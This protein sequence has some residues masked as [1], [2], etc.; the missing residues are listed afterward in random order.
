MRFEDVRT[1]IGPSQGHNLALTGLFVPSSL[2][3]GT[4][5]ADRNLCFP[6]QVDTGLPGKENSRPVH[7]IISL[8]KRIRTSRL[9]I[10]NSLSLDRNRRGGVPGESGVGECGTLASN[11]FNAGWCVGGWGTLALQKLHNALEASERTAHAKGLAVLK[12]ENA[13]QPPVR[14]YSRTKSWARWWSWGEGGGSD[15]RGAPLHITLRF[16]VGV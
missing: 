5:Q 7:Q 10:K 15:E 6:R 8:N 9:S 12:R 3:S 13:K 2:D 4:A 1:E 14:P 11:G 16:R